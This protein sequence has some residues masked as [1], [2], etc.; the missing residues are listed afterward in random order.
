MT[1][2]ADRDRQSIRRV[3]GLRVHTQKACNP[4][5]NAILRSRTRTGN[6]DLHG[7]RRIIYHPKPPAAGSREHHA[8]HFPQPQCA[9]NISSDKGTLKRHHVWLPTIE[10][11]V[12]LAGNYGEPFRDVAGLT[13]SDPGSQLTQLASGLI[14]YAPTRLSR[15]RIDPEHPHYPLRLPRK[16]NW[17]P[18]LLASARRR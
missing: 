5:R 9:G 10:N 8:P 1:N 2:V 17:L 18:L 15:S 3:A 16:T 6:G 11:F 7:C 4:H 14:D 12:D 13:R